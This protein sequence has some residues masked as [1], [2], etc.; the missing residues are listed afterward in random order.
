MRSERNGACLRVSSSLLRVWHHDKSVVSAIDTK[1]YKCTPRF[2]STVL[3]IGGQLFRFSVRA[4]VGSQLSS[5]LEVLYY[6]QSLH[7]GNP[8]LPPYKDSADM[9]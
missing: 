5:G 7:V 2:V 6:G 3:W 4:V 1:F 9:Q 8:L